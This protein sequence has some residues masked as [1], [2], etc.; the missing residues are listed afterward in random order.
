MH[1]VALRLRCCARAMKVLRT[2]GQFADRHIRHHG[3]RAIWYFVGFVAVCAVFFFVSYEVV[4]LLGLL[5]AFGHFAAAYDRWENWFL[6]KRGE[7]AVTRALSALPGE[8][9][10]LNDVM[11][12]NR[13]GNVDH[14]LIG[15]NGLFVIETK[16]YAAHIKCDGDQW[17]RNGKPVKSLSWQV[18]I[19]AIAVRKN[20][21]AVFAQHR[22]YLPFVEPILVFVK[23]THRLE[24]N[25]P[26]VHVLKAEELVNFLA[27]Y[28]PRSRAVRFT[29]ELVRA[30]VHHLQS[31]QNPK[32]V[33]VENAAEPPR[34]AQP[35]QL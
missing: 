32:T 4:A 16:N 27:N 2:G 19:N 31:L 1:R 30:T 21:Q 12:P 18:K 17:F 6:G 7:L 9:V 8:Y 33:R 5:L 24:L 26:S 28:K 25:Y 3:R 14:F 11:L 22:A 23:H 35:A 20:L 13:R 34:T 15:P 10:L 29:P